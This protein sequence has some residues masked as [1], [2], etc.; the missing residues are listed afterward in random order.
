M[1]KEPRLACK[2]PRGKE[3]VDLDCIHILQSQG[4]KEEGKG[5][6]EKDIFIESRAKQQWNKEYLKPDEN[7]PLCPNKI[8]HCLHGWVNPGNVRTVLSLNRDVALLCWAN[9]YEFKIN[10][11]LNNQSGFVPKICQQILSSSKVLF[12]VLITLTENKKN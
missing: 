1:V 10:F 9:T 6:R 7:Q 5:G 11:I 12:L 8:T 2:N 3:K 4:K